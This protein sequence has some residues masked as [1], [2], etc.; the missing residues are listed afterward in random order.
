[1]AHKR[2]EIPY[3]IQI[4]GCNNCEVRE[5]YTTDTGTY[6]EQGHPLHAKCV[7]TGCVKY[8]FNMEEPFITPSEYIRMGKELNWEESLNKA[9]EIIVKFFDFYDSR[10]NLL[11]WVV[12]AISQ[13]EEEK[14]TR[15]KVA[16]PI[17]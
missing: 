3:F 10:G 9:K 17:S 12:E 8:G 14:P 13:K 15:V 16:P 6:Y 2:K 1:M 4:E 11:P 7:H 5:A